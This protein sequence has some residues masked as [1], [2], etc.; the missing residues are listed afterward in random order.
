M[1]DSIPED[2]RMGE[3]VIAGADYLRCELDLAARREMIVELDDFLRR[4]SKI[5]LVMPR[6]ELERADGLRTACQILFGDRAE[7]KLSRYLAR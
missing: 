5:A 4:R 1:I 2:P 3:A 7:E 6:D